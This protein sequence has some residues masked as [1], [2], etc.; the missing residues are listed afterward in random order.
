MSR[1]TCSWPWHKLE[2]SG[3]LH[4]PVALF[5]KKEPLH[6]LDWRLGG[7]QIRSGLHGKEN[8]LNHPELEICL[9]NK[10]LIQNINGENR[11]ETSSWKMINWDPLQRLV[12][13]HWR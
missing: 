10:K 5:L 2:L 8:I 11:R 7:Q 3:V 13:L 1:S 6:T 9:R 4:A 12:N